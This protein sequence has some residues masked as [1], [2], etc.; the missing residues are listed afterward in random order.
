MSPSDATPFNASKI[1]AGIVAAYVVK[2]SLQL[3]DLP[4]LIHSVHTALTQL[5]SGLGNSAPQAEKQE[6]AVAVRKSITPDYLVCL[7]D[8]KRFK[9]L[10][11]HLATLVLTPDQYRVKWNLPFD[12]PM[13]APNSSAARSEMA[14][15]IGLGQIRTTAPPAKRGRPTKVSV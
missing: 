14:K 12:Y 9:S 1:T 10:R 13:V 7:E 3:A 15:R 6:P 5:A 11:R 2:N 8:G 4:V